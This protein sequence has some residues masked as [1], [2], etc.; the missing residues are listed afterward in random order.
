MTGC[1]A[2]SEL[3]GEIPVEPAAQ[4]G[5]SQIS[6]EYKY[7]V[8]ALTAALARC[9]E[10]HRLNCFV[11]LPSNL[12]SL[13]FGLCPPASSELV[14]SDPSE[15]SYVPEDSPNIANVST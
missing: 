10:P 3:P 12:N 15:H 5:L 7:E 11:R 1:R 2:C 14:S 9:K 8:S 13:L 6:L 4:A